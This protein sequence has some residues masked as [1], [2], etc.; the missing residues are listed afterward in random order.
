MH[1][2]DIKVGQ[3]YKNSRCGDDIY[4][5]IG[6]RTMWEG[7][8]STFESNFT[9]KALVIIKSEEFLGQIMQ[10]PENCREGFWDDFYEAE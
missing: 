1:P 7:K 6:L 8:F 4:L 9:N 3:T 10:S 5:G 2:N